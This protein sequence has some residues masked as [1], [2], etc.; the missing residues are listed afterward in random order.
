MLNVQLGLNVQLCSLGAGWESMDEHGLLVK[1]G[2][3]ADGS[4]RTCKG[5]PAWG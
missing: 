3:V 4:A 1:Q 2:E 5:S